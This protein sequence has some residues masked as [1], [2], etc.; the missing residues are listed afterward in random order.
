MHVRK[1]S[2]RRRRRSGWS[3]EPWA[4]AARTACT[5]MS[6]GRRTWSSS[7]S[8]EHCS[9][10]TDRVTGCLRTRNQSFKQSKMIRIVTSDITSPLPL[11]GCHLSR[12]RSGRC[13]KSSSLAMTAK[14][15]SYQNPQTSS[16]ISVREQVNGS[17][18]ERH[19]C[20]RVTS[21]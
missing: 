4:A 14:H 9:T 18:S 2:W 7:A 5:A 1:R 6:P 3:P 10:E 13:R 11:L 15:R 8:P 20:L 21:V 19:Q 17:N 16:A 12:R